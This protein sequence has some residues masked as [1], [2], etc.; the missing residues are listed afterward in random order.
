MG[1]DTGIS[2]GASQVLVFPIGD[3][4]VCPRV[5]V[6]LGQAKVDNVDKVALFP[7]APAYKSYKL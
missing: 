1:V 2:G 3:V 6:L 4:L 5:S 7:Q